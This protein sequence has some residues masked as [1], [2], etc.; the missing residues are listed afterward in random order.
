MVCNPII[1]PIDVN[2]GEIYEALEKL[3]RL[4]APVKELWWGE[5]KYTFIPV[6]NDLRVTI[7]VGQRDTHHLGSEQKG[8]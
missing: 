7:N 2:D 4:P 6:D 5:R 3:L 1:F 8:P